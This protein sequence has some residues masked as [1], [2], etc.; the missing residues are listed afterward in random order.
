MNPKLLPSG[1]KCVICDA[2]I[3]QGRVDLIP[4]T[5]VCVKHSHEDA[6]CGFQVIRGK[7]DCTSIQVVSRAT[8]QR[9]NRLSR[10]AGTGVSQGMKN[11]K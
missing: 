6:V 3:P 9:L 8:W 5:T 4:N 2:D 7:N 10:R 1:R 11:S